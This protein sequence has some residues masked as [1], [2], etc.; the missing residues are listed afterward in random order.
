ML[1][2]TIRFSQHI[3]SDPYEVELVARI[4]DYMQA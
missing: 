4:A 2:T 3:F 1:Y